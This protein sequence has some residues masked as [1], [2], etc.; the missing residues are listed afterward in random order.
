MNLCTNAGFAMRDTGG[1]LNVALAETDIRPDSTVAPGL[2]PG[3]VRG[4]HRRDTG[5]GM[6]RDVMARVFEPFFTTKEVGQGTGM[7]LAVVY[8]IVKTLHGDITVKSAPG[9]GSTFRVFLPK[10]SEDAASYDPVQEATG[11]KER[12]LFIDDEELVAELG[13]GRLEKLG[14]KVTAM[15]DG[16]EALKAFS[17]N[18]SQFDLVFTDQTMPEITG[19]ALA[20]ELLKYDRT[21]RLSSAPATASPSQRKRRWLL[22]S[23]DS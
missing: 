16:M 7:G 3:A 11:G 13:K 20:Q 23:G 22:E 18:P 15:T 14:Y 17:T 21:F 1:E 2:P 5:T 10:V 4:A 12:I 19:F 6:D 9:T 8:G